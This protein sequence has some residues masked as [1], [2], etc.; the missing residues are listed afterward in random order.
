[1]FVLILHGLFEKIKG[2]EMI[3]VSYDW[4]WKTYLSTHGSKNQVKN[5]DKHKFI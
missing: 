3:S 2:K 5:Q 1:M 4:Q